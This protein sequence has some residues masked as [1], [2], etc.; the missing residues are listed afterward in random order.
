MNLEDRSQFIKEKT[1]D[2]KIYTNLDQIKSYL[3]SSYDLQIKQFVIGHKEIQGA[4]VFLS[5][6]EDPRAIE[7]IIGDLTSELHKANLTPENPKEAFNIAHRKILSNEDM[8]PTDN[9]ADIFNKILIGETAILIDGVSQAILCDTKEW[10]TRGIEEPEAE[11]TIRGPREGFIESLRVNTGLVRRRIRSPNLWMEKVTVGQEAGNEVAFAYLKGLAHEDLINEVR[12]RLENIDL[13]GV[14]E[15][16]YV[17]EMIEDTPFTLFPLTHRTERV[18]IV[19]SA[20]LEGKVA[21]FTDGT[22]FVMIVPIKFLELLQAPDDYHEKFPVGTLIRLGRHI[23]FLFSI[24]FPG[25][26]VAVINFHP[27]LLPTS[28][29]LQITAARQGVPFPAAMEVLLMEFLFELLREAGLRL[30]GMIGPALGIVGALILGDAAIGAGLVSPAVVVVVALTAI[31]SFIVPA[32][33]LAIAGRITRFIAVLF[34]S[35]FGLFG[36]QFVFLLLG[37]HLCSLRSFG[38]PYMAPVGPLIKSDWKDAI[39]RVPWPLQKTRPKLEG[40][41]DPSKQKTQFPSPPQGLETSEDQD[42]EE[43][44]EVEN[45]SDSKDS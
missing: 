18:D 9:F 33:S 2:K 15:S 25:A 36:I 4:A 12:H 30:P 17:E 19:S 28:L 13:D 29:M 39:L 35:A 42:H 38:Y 24:F 23:G 43:Q 1:L 10:E 37:L 40:G 31:S 3:G 14:L 27:E 6:L 20:I 22:P 41:K 44:P 45:D 11:K 26:Y 7:R 34:G 8:L 16:G 21:I 5:G 32:Y